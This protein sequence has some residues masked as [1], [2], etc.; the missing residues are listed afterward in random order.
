MKIKYNRIS[1][2]SQKLDR[3]QLNK[4]QFD[5]IIDE[6]C[7]GSISFFERKESKKI[8]N[9]I[10]LNKVESLH[11][12]SIDRIGR[13]ILDILLVSEYL[14]K[15]LVNLFVENIGIY[16]MINNRPNPT[17]KLIVSVLG[18]VAEMERETLLE[19]QKAGIAI[20]KLKGVYKGRTKGT[21]Q[22]SENF[23]KKYQVAYNELLN[24]ST[25]KRSSLLGEC[26]IG[27]TQRLKKLIISN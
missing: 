23:I 6:V 12:T 3:Q 18:N 14:Q 1:S 10:R 2:S 22:S 24:G 15:N 5:L 21:K 20:A 13:N 9:L 25:L 7:S 16:S 4:K 17:F 26:S 8:I 19:R 11:I 27:T